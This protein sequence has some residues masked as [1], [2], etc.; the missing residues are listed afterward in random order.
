MARVIESKFD[1]KAA[2]F[3]GIM[4]MFLTNTVIAESVWGNVIS[5][6]STSHSTT[7]GGWGNTTSN[8]RNIEDTVWGNPYLNKSASYP[9]IH[10]NNGYWQNGTYYPKVW[11]GHIDMSYDQY[12]CSQRQY[13]RWGNSGC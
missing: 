11:G 4:G 5:H 10:D 7:N 1:V 12:S 9:K 2:L 6:D 8:N 3:I 13:G